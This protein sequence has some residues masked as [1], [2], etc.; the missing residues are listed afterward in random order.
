ME[1]EGADRR[2]LGGKLGGG[3][4]GAREQSLRD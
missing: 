3:R 2:R 1:N 4:P